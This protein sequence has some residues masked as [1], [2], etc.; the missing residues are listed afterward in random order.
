MKFGYAP[1]ESGDYRPT[2]IHLAHTLT[3]RLSEVRKNG[4]LPYLRPDG[5]S[6]VTAE[7]GPGHKPRRLDAVVISTQHADSID[8]QTLR[9]DTLNHVIQAPLP[10]QLLDPDPTYHTTPTAP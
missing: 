6:Q 4:T 1:R 2:P 9:A 3:Q 7:Y 10:A 8:N 5:K